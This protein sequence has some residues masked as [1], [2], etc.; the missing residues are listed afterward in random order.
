MPNQIEYALRFA[1]IWN[2]DRPQTVHVIT[3]EES[4]LIRRVLKE[5]GTLFPPDRQGMESRLYG[6]SAEDFYRREK[7]EYAQRVLETFHTVLEG[8]YVSDECKEYL[9]SHLE[10]SLSFGLPA[11]LV[12]PLESLGINL[13]AERYGIFDPSADLKQIEAGL[14]EW[15]R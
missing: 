12:C 11:S 2:L 9:T 8:A 4:D 15:K 5:E 7:G 14:L 1:E 13:E 6:G 3:R 10:T